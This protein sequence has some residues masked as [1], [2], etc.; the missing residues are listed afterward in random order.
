MKKPH[1]KVVIED[2][3][4]VW[5]CNGWTSESQLGAWIQWWYDGDR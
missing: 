2:G 3:R 4:A 5:W 1:M